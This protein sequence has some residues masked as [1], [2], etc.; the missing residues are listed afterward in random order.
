MNSIKMVVISCLFFIACN[1]SKQNNSTET[2]NEKEVAPVLVGNDADAHGCKASAGYQW[3]EIKQECIRV[4]E[5]G[6]RLNPVSKELDQTTSA[7]IVF[8]SATDISQ[9]EVFMPNKEKSMLFQLEEG[10]NL[11]KWKYDN[12]ELIEFEKGFY[13]II[14]STNH[15]LYEGKEKQN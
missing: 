4:F 6:I 10:N 15:S 5:V 12:F 3:S 1:T 13:K 14:D 7:F 2:K 9:A 11:S 8:K